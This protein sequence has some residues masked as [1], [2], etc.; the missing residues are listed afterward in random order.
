MSRRTTLVLLALA[1]LSALVAA[2]L[3]LR[4]LSPNESERYRDGVTVLGHNRVLADSDRAAYA[5][6]V[7]D[8]LSDTE[9]AASVTAPLVQWF[10]EATISD[11][12]LSLVVEGYGHMDGVRCFVKVHRIRPQ[13]A[14]GIIGARHLTEEQRAGLN[15]GALEALKVMVLCDPQDTG[16]QDPVP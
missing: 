12:D 5:F 16:P 8:E 9:V 7:G 14:V 11:G 4:P 3:I 1:V 13:A 10:H 6:F 2:Y 15:S